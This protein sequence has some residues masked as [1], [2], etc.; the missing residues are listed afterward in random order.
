MTGNEIRQS[1]LQYFESRGH[2]LVRS[3][4]LVPEGDPTLLFTNAGMNQFKNTFLGK[5]RRDYT[6]AASCQKCMR[7]GG[8]HNDLENVGRTARHHTFFEMLG[9]F[10]FGDYFKAEAIEFAWELITKVY[11]LDPGRLYA[12]IFETD[13]E[14]G[15]LWRRISGLPPGRILRFGEKDNFWAMGDTGPCGPCSEILYDL[16]ASPAGHTD[17]GPTCDCGRHLEIWNLVFMQYERDHA[18]TL[19]PLPAPSIDTGMGLERLTSVLQGKLSNY[20]TDLFMPL[21]RETEAIAGAR[22]GADSKADLSLRII[23]DHSRA[24][25]FL[26]ADGVLPSNEGRGYVL[27]KILRRAIRHGRMLGLHEPFM[28]RL[29]GTVTGGMGGMYDELV[30]HR[31]YVARVLRA[32]EEKFSATL[33]FGLKKLEEVVAGRGDGA[34][35]GGTDIFK[36]YDTFGFPT[37]LLAEI[38]EERGWRLDMDGFAAE[39]AQQK[40]RARASWKGEAQKSVP[41]AIRDLAETRPAEFVGYETIR[42]DDARVVA[43]L[44]GGERMAALAEGEEGDVVLDRTPF[45]AESGGQVGDQ[46]SLSAAAGTGRVLDVQTP[47]GGVILHRTRVQ[48]G[49]LRAG[50]AVAAAVDADRRFATACHHTATHLL[51]AGLR[52]VLGEHVKQAGSLVSPERLRFD[53]THFTAVSPTELA[54]IEAVANE[55]IWRD[56]TVR[57]DV[58]AIDE[59]V[60]SGAMA[61][62]GEKYQETVRVVAV[63]GFSRELCGGTHLQRTGQ[64][65]VFKIAAESSIASGVRRIEAVAGPTAYRRYVEAEQLLGQLQRALKVDAAELPGA[66]GELQATSHHHQ[67]EVERLRL[68]LASG[69][70]AA[71]AAGAA[72]VAGVQVAGGVVADVDRNALRS[73]ADQLLRR[74][75]RAVVALGAE[76]DGKAALV[77]MVSESEAKRLP[78]RQ[79]AQDLAA[80]VEGS[81]GGRPAMAEAG[82]KN[83]ARLGEAVAALPQLVEK[84]AAR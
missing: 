62:F 22:Y 13:D 20:D 5:E 27:R 25:V 28:H 47:V 71:I 63:E 43:I 36:L 51:H 4:P 39:L 55:Q 76:I 73:L 32:E 8:K 83:P 52:E 67:K 46:G 42:V 1:F 18:G 24:G 29:A 2:R 17:C 41:A 9:N 68:R 69:A 44:R 21:I 23:A 33:D 3:S 10:S 64:M 84:L 65:G 54:A 11:G 60:A 59:A 34:A 75:E 79:L 81:G 57:T 6:R 14:S 31:D 66:V 78:A 50:D 37:D 61:L 16:G 49:A 82:G 38:A 35:I 56:R 45:Y 70:M 40:E 80:I 58:M 7:A 77:V 26:V 48:Q 19:H 74:F 12:T 30:S 15:D 53:F 72:E